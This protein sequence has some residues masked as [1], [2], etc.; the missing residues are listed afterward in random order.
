M[1]EIRRERKKKR[2]G[3]ERRSGGEKMGIVGEE[4]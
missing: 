3:K 2:N 4:S 1:M